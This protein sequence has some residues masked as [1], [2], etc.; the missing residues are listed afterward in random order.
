[1]GHLQS[2]TRTLL[3][4]PA[5]SQP[6]RKRARGLTPARRRPGNPHGGP[7][8]GGLRPRL[9]SESQLAA[10]HGLA[11]SL[12]AFQLALSIYT[13]ESYAE[14]W[15]LVLSNMAT[16]YLSRGGY[17]DFD[18]L[19]K[20]VALM[21]QVVFGLALSRLPKSD[22]AN[23]QA[24]A[25]DALRAAYDV[26]GEL[27]ETTRQRFICVM[28]HDSGA[29]FL[30]RTKRGAAYN[31]GLTLARSDDPAIAEEAC[32][33][34]EES[35]PWLVETNQTE[36]IEDA[37]KLLSQAYLTL[38]RS[39]PDVERGDR[40]CRRALSVLKDH[41]NSDTAMQVVYHV[42]TWLLQHADGYPD[43]ADLAGAAFERVLG[44]L[45]ATDYPELRAAALANFATVL[46]LRE[47]GTRELN[48]VRARDSLEEALRILRSL[49]PTPEREERIGL[50]LMNYG[51]SGFGIDVSGSS[52]GSPP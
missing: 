8:S 21:E 26:F 30:V 9:Q 52:S 12:S 27:G 33:R 11:Q 1:M 40:I 17:T 36:Q 32:G 15:A 18:D 14:D 28:A 20:S 41:T 51:H 46:L 42:G 4:Q 10:G 35:L 3:R 48:R 47:R 39:G 24:R 23:P 19:L 22:A 29:F 43:R 31:L 7:V 13:K 25:V 45:Q 34:L 49:P 37:I 16:A 6:F 38:L 44:H 50:I 5:R 2:R